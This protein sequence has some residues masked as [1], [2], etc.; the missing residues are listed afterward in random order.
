MK[1]STIIFALFVIAAFAQSGFGQTEKELVINTARAVEE[2]PFD[3]ETI[4][5]REQALKYVIETDQVSIIACGGVMSPFL[6]KKN[7]FGSDLTVAYTLGMAAFKLGNP[8]K[9][10]D[11]NAAQL[12]GLE[13][14]LKSYETM[15]KEKP[16][17]KFEPVE[18]LLAKRSNSELTKYVAD[19]NCK[20]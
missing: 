3:K 12:A 16:K 13:S 19:A 8:D 6:D 5:M 1:K 14:A 10:V 7:K 4:K 17:G 11:E 2:K 15:L 9:A 20:K 18:A